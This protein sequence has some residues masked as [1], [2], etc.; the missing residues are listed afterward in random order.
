MTINDYIIIERCATP[1]LV[2][3]MKEQPK[4]AYL[5]DRSSR[6][7]LGRLWHRLWHGEPVK[8][9]ANLNHL[10]YGD[11]IDLQKSSDIRDFILTACRVVLGVDDARRVFSEKAEPM[12][13]FANW[14]ASELKRID[15]LFRAIERPFTPEQLQAGY[16]S[17]NFGEFGTLDWYAKRMG[18][19]NH[20]YVLTVGW[21]VLYQVKR[22]DAKLAE[23]E[24]RHAKIMQA[25]NER[26]GRK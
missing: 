22:N 19:V 26:R 6:W 13:G 12:V 23:C 9:P 7:W 25:K 3:R 10:T 16:G 11:L 18:I 21:S 1:E 14:V 4:P 20:D 15:A 8:V 5:F 17:L 2:A 24:E